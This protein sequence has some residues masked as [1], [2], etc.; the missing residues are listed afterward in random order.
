MNPINLPA[1]MNRDSDR[2]ATRTARGCL[3]IPL[4]GIVIGFIGQI[5]PIKG[6]TRLLHA[7]AELSDNPT[8]HLIVAGRDPHPGAEHEGVCKALAAELGIASRVQFLGYLEETARFYQAIDLVVVPSLIEPLGR[9]PL[10]AGAHGRP[11]LAYAVGGLPE[12]IQQGLTGTLVSPDR[13]EELRDGLRA[14]LGDKSTLGSGEAARRW[15]EEIAD[16]S[17]Y[18]ARIAC[19]Y[20]ELRAN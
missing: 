4:D 12:T 10:E 15:V 17:R 18:A 2:E 11:A 6:L 13:P 14:F 16:P 5:V 19:M 8:W 9:V 3:G 1:R 20:S 7:L